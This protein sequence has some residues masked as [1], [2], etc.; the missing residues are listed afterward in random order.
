M[1]VCCHF[2]TWRRSGSKFLSMRSAP[3]EEGVDQAE[4]LGVLCE[5]RLKHARNNVVMFE[6][7]AHDFRPNGFITHPPAMILVKAARGTMW[8]G[9]P[10]FCQMLAK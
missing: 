2:S 4:A 1:W 7:Q 6:P 5:N 3:T 10:I 9:S 8:V